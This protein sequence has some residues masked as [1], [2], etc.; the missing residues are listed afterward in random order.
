MT[1][2]AFY[3]HFNYIVDNS[4]INHC[5]APMIVS[6]EIKCVG[7]ITFNTKCSQRLIAFLTYL[8][9]IM[10]C[11]ESTFM[12]TSRC[13]VLCYIW[14]E[15]GKKLSHCFSID[16]DFFS[17]DFSYVNQPTHKVRQIFR[18]LFSNWDISKA[19]LI[20]W[21]NYRTRIN[22]EASHNMNLM[23]YIG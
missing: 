22:N 5:K 17:S 21:Y 18:K 7:W 14:R 4:R 15:E 1:K 6:K 16:M 12:S 19:N 23:F 8:T 2:S 20:S 10:K 3:T 11:K 9:F 13:D